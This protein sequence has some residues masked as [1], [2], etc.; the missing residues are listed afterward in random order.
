LR[1]GLLSPWSSPE[2]VG[3]LR[4]LASLP[5]VDE[6]APDELDLLFAEGAGVT[7]L[8]RDFEVTE[9]LIAQKSKAA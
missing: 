3:D 6:I 1:Y 7:F 9:A 4:R 2:Y 5:A 8:D